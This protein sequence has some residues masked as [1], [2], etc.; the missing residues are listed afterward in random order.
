MKYLIPTIG[1]LLSGYGFLLFFGTLFVTGLGFFTPILTVGTLIGSITFLLDRRTGNVILLTMAAVWLL[2]YFEHVSYLIYYDALNSGRWILV[3]IPLFL[4]FWLF[5]L[6]YKHRREYRK[7]E[8]GIK[9]LGIA[10]I[11]FFS[12]GMISFVWK[13]HTD[14]FNCWYY[15]DEESG[16]IKISFSIT[17]DHI[18]E[19]TNNSP[20]LKEIIEKE[21]LTYES[22]DGYYCPETKV[23]IISSFKKV[24][25]IK[26]LG[27]RNSELDKHVK[28]SPPIEIDIQTISGDLSL[29][30]TPFNLGD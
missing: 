21:G 23:R 29:L 1:F 26:I 28:F 5:G 4:A 17:P 12:I 18:F 27:F 8:T 22:R 14:E 13:P 9:Q 15:I 2:R 30:E 11:V 20:K 7:K 10:F 24:I 19:A 16:N 25:A 3:G 6:T